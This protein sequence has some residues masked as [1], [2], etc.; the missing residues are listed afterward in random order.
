MPSLGEERP[1]MTTAL[2]IGMPGGIE[3][4]VILAIEILLFG[5][6]K[7][8]G[9]ARSSGEAIGEFKKGREQIEREI[10]AAADGSVETDEDAPE[11]ESA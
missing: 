4:L 1:D 10:R 8:P 7:L 5:A 3:L 6:N 2:I 9:L 11:S